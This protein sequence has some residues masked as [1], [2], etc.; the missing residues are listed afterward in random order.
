MQVALLNWSCDADYMLDLHCDHFAVLHLY[1]STARPGDT[2]L[3]CRASGAR[4]ALIEDVSGGNAFDE[5]HTVPWLHLRQRFG[6]RI[7]AGMLFRREL[8]PSCLR[9]QGLA[10]V[11]GETIVRSGDLLSD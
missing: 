1:A 5:A 10:H 8:W 3:L 6:D 2:S 11:A 9:G 7:P 4:L